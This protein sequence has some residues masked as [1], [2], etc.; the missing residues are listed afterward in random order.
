MIRRVDL[1]IDKNSEGAWLISALVGGYLIT[2]RY[3]FHT[4]RE[5]VDLFLSEVRQSA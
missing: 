2:R 1:T 4:K 5:A 3:Y